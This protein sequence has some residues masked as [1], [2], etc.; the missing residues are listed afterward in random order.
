MA[1][2]GQPSMN[3]VAQRA[4]VS[5]Q[6]VS[7]VLNAPDKVHP[8]TR[9]RVREAMEELGYR[10]NLA[11]RALARSRSGLLGVLSSGDGRFG[12][13]QAIHAI[14][15]AA[16]RAG[17]ITTHAPAPEGTDTR[18]ALSHL[19][20]AGVEGVVVVAPTMPLV[21]LMRTEPLGVPVVLVSALAKATPGI[22]VVAADQ[23]AGARM[24]VGHLIA[25]GHTRISHISGPPGWFDSLARLEGWQA[26]LAAHD[27]T[28]AVL[29]RGGWDARDGY[30]GVHELMRDPRGTTAVFTANDLEALGAVR[31]FNELGLRVPEDISLVGFDDIEGSDFFLPPLTTVRQ[32]FADVGRRAIGVLIEM[33]DGAPSHAEFLLPTL[34][35]RDSTCPLG[36]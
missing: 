30:D 23:E 36:S 14:E 32:P 35:V 4:G 34:V 24:A 2:S 10:R 18:R 9:E 21:Q 15:L 12:P 28:P 1:A 27:L 11:A 29:V 8:E 20:D 31:A 25:Q 16:R 7:R 17:Y 6:T 13:T 3:D 5:H 19:L 33:V 22:S 26:E